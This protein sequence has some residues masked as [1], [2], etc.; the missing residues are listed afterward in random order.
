MSEK[1]NYGALVAGVVLICMGALALLDR[2]FQGTKFWEMAW[3]L[4]IIGC[5]VLFF[6]G[7]FVAGK[8]F[9]WLAI[10][11]SII[12]ANGVMLFL[13]NLTGR[14]ETWS[15]SWTVILMSIGVGIFI[16][17]AWQGD[18]SRRRAGLKLFEVGAV[19]F[20]IFGAF[21]EIL[22]SLGVPDGLRGYVFPIGLLLLGIYLVV[23]RSGLLLT[24]TTK[25]SDQHVVVENLGNIE[26][27]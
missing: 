27:K 6:V 17:G 16:M 21:F 19:L 9:A 3:P 2:I 25:S 14:W 13:Q 8:S 12:A 18:K 5:G 7:M 10:P 20:V 22:F 4:I 11:G 23:K 26:I 1:R 24:R 15:Y